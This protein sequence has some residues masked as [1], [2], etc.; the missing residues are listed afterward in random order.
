MWSTIG[1]SAHAAWSAAA[2]LPSARMRARSPLID[3]STG[4]VLALWSFFV[5]SERPPRSVHVLRTSTTIVRT[6]SPVT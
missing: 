4:T 6:D 1:D 3:G 2:A 5:R